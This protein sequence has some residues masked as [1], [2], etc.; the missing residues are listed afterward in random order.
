MDS[1]LVKL[2][3]QTGDCKLV[4]TVVDIFDNVINVEISRPEVLITIAKNNVISGPYML[5]VENE[6]AFDHLKRT[7]SIGDLVDFD[8][9]KQ[10]S[11]NNNCLIFRTSYKWQCFIPPM[12]VNKSK[13]IDMYEEVNS[14]LK[15]KGESGGILNAYLS[16]TLNDDE[17][18]VFQSIY[19]NYFRQLIQQLSEQFDGENLKRFVGLGI[20]LTPSGDDFIVGVLAVLYSYD[21]SRRFIHEIKSEINKESIAGKTTRVS[22]HMLNFALNG[23]FNLAL[24]NLFNEKEHLN[25]SLERI[26]SIGSTSGTDMLSGVGFTL[27][28]LIK[29]YKRRD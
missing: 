11:V 9:E 18:P 25:Q 7:V 22:T 23:Q 12:E 16:R 14:F 21:T 17:S 28:H 27:E 15:E 6:D 20:G 2:I 19:D 29:E 24:L 8:I 5:K 26:K 1:E 13:F 3:N 4:G 10:I